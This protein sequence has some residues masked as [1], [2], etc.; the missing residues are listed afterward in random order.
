M[1]LS[2]MFVLYPISET[3]WFKAFPDVKAN[4]CVHVSAI[5]EFLVKNP[6][7]DSTLSGMI[8]PFSIA[9]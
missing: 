1:T 3:V 2:C 8:A 7:D 5:Q 9:L 4:K 6:G